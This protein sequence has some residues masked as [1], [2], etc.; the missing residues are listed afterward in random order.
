[1]KQ[2]VICFVTLII[3]ATGIASN[4]WA[5][6]RGRIVSGVIKTESDMVAIV[7][8]D[9]D[10]DSLFLEKL[11]PDGESVWV[12]SYYDASWKS[13]LL[14]TFDNGF[15][16]FNRSRIM[17]TDSLGEILWNIDRGAYGIVELDDTSFYMCNSS[18][19][20]NLTI[21]GDTSLIL[22]SGDIANIG[23]GPYRSFYTVADTLAIARYASTG[24]LYYWTDVVESSWDWQYPCALTP[25]SG[26]V[27]SFRGLFR[28]NRTGRD[29]YFYPEYPFLSP[30]GDLNRCISALDVC[31]YEGG[32]AVVGSLGVVNAGVY[33]VTDSGDFNWYRVI[34][35]GGLFTGWRQHTFHC[36]HA[37]FNG[38]LLIG[39]RVARGDDGRPGIL[40]STDSLGY[41]AREEI[42]SEVGWNLVSYVYNDTITPANSAFPGLIE[43]TVWEWNGDSYVAEDSVI[44][45]KGYFTLCESATDTFIGNPAEGWRFNLVRGWNLIGSVVDTMNVSDLF[46]EPSSSFIPPIYGWNGVDYFATDIIVPGKAYWI[47]LSSPA[48]V[49]L[50]R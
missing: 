35:G 1:M 32:Y 50:T 47:L 28:F 4:Y 3:C 15:I 26:M 44:A 19:V 2:V 6:E 17:R 46:V 9:Y 33:S 37:G 7:Y 41:Y 38:G 20:Y 18:G 36:V 29:S 49:R 48:L 40:I 43:P 30:G 10:I 22:A 39:G 34:G 27:V 21:E 14:E 31:S 42:E 25:D 11:T 12:H 13:D 16:I 23:I 5:V 8:Y 24:A 45:G